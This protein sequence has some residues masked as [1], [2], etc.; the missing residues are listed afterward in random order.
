M[1]PFKFV[2]WLVMNRPHFP[3]NCKLNSIDLIIHDRDNNG[4]DSPQTS[5]FLLFFF[6]TSFRR[7]CSE[8][9]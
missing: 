5:T 7:L 1:V 4:P 3:G 2:T 8:S 9:L 6:I